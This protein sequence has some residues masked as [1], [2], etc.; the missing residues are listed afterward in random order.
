[1]DYRIKKRKM[2]SAHQI[3]MVCL[4]QLVGSE[5]QYRKFKELFN[6]GAAE[7]ELKGIE[8]PANYKG[9][10]VLRLFKCLLLQFMEDLSVLSH[11]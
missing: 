10:G 3:I 1:M 8:S 4:D 2:S 5:H 7:Q 11:L 9:Y 6:F